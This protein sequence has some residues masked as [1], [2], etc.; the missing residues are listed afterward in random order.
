MKNTAFI[1]LGANLKRKK[2]LSLQENIQ[3]ALKYFPDYGISIIKISEA[4][5]QQL[6]F[7]ENE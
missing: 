2:D 3:T 7:I 6:N 1:A 5:R 4:V